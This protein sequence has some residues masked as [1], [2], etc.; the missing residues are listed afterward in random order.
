MVKK[1]MRGIRS[2]LLGSVSHSV[3]HHSPIP[4]LVVSA[5]GETRGLAL[6]A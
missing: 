3:L 4:I 6:S 5:A 2:A 1:A